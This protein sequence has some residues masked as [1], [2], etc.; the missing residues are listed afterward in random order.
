M[1]LVSTVPPSNKDYILERD[2][3]KRSLNY[4][5]EA[6]C[7]FV[8]DVCIIIQTR[9]NEEPQQKCLKGT[10]KEI[11]NV[12]CDLSPFSC[13]T[14][15]RDVQNF[16]MDTVINIIIGSW[17]TNVNRLLKGKTNICKNNATKI[18]A[19]NYYI[20]HNRKK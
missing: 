1:H 17:C 10:I 6:L 4:P 14:H 18:Q 3:T 12:F 13:V 19:L 2:I 11:A 7:Q 8:D 15:K 9:L 16:V 20:K 5:S